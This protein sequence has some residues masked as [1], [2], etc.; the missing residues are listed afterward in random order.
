MVKLKS[1]LFV[2]NKFSGG[3]YRPD[4]EGLI[5]EQCKKLNIESTI[6]FTQNPGHATELAKGAVDQKLDFVFAV[7][8]DGTVNEVAQ[9]LLGSQV[10]MGILPRGSGNGLA[11]H[12]SIPMSFKKALEIIPLHRTQRIDTLSVNGKLSVNVSGIGFDG[13]VAGLF[14][15]K[16]KRGLVGYAKLV[17]KE[18]LSFKSFEAKIRMNGT[19]FQSK[20]FIIALANSSQFG[21]NARVAPQASVCDQLIDVCFIQKVPMLQAIGFAR[22]MFSGRLDQSRFVEIIKTNQV[23][24]ELD[25]S[26]SYHIDGEAMAGTDKFIVELKPASLKILVPHVSIAQAKKYPI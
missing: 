26:I 21:N 5:I 23:T 24:I 20:S 12:L 18:F 15:N 8:G 22:K 11:R 1:A 10:T 4:V 14:A 19:S 9:G 17:L 13:H 25:E 16:A 2:V 7:G 3:G 6:E